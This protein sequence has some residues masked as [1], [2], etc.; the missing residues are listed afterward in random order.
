MSLIILITGC[1]QT[2][3]VGTF[4]YISMFHIKK[5]VIHKPSNDKD[6]IQLIIYLSNIFFIYIKYFDKL[7]PVRIHPSVIIKG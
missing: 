5:N 1:F 3:F 7:V 2:I 4:D 6:P